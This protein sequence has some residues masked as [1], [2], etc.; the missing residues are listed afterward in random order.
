M[1]TILTISCQKGG[2]AKTTTAASVAGV[3][4]SERGKRVLLV[5]MDAQRN[6]TMTFSDGQFPRTVY[7]AFKDESILPVYSVRENLDIVPASPYMSEI[8][9]TYGS[10]P[11]WDTLLKEMLD[12]L[13]GDYDWIIIDT[14]AQKGILTMTS[15]VAADYVLIPLSGDGYAADGFA[16]ALAVINSVRRRSNRNLDILGVLQTRY[17][18][19]RKADRLVD[20][21]LRENAPELFFDVKIR[22]CSAFVQAALMRTD[23]CSFKPASNAAVDTRL[24]VDEILAR[25]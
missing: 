18:A 15:L 7:D 5:D 23:V 24:L 12:P 13:R 8:D 19:R 16:D 14:P 17:D 3:L 11:G 6:L 22:E 25:M 21:S 20:A 9:A 1:A 2:T 4:A 10:V